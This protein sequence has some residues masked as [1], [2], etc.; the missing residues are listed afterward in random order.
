MTVSQH[1]IVH[2]ADEFKKKK[3]SKAQKQFNQLIKKIAE[4]KQL[5]LEWQTTLPQYNQRL[6]ESYTP[7]MTKFNQQRIEWLHLLDRAYHNNDFSN[8]DKKKLRH[9]L[10]ELSHELVVSH[11]QVELTDL[12]NR[13]AAGEQVLLIDTVMQDAEADVRFAKKIPKDHAQPDKKT[14]KQQQEQE[15][16]SKSIQS[17]YRQLVA[18]LHPDREPDEQERERKTKLM[19]KVNVAYGKKDLLQLLELQLAVEQIDQAHLNNLSE[20]RLKHFNKVLQEQFTEL[21]EEVED[22]E[23]AFKRQMNLAAKVHLSPKYLM[24][25]L[26]EAMKD[27]QRSIKGLQMN[28]KAAKDSAVLKSWLRSYQIPKD[29]L[30]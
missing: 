1:G 13:Y 25:N 8:A 17:V 12:Y 2:I 4:Q 15:K 30:F 20:D 6:S 27:L 28:N 16:I 10:G 26:D 14:A 11:G 24:K 18:S 19:Q 22:I 29:T 5:L 21:S 23:L 7:L 3:L 9:L